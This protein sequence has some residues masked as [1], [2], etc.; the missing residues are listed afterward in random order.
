M[1]KEEKEIYA[2]KESQENSKNIS[3]EDVELVIDKISKKYQEKTG[4][5]AVSSFME[6]GCYYFAIMLKKIFGDEAKV[7]TSMAS[8]GDIH[9]ITKINENYYDINGNIN[10][11]IDRDGYNRVGID[12]SKYYEA[13]QEDLYY[14]IDVCQLGVS[15]QHIK[16]FELLCD[17]IVDEIK[18]EQKENYPKIL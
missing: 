1:L 2:N 8:Y 16:E 5:Y 3:N 11:L 15:S 18:E 10:K 4:G 14:F 9:A 17:E 6:G 13:T 12:I 7:Y